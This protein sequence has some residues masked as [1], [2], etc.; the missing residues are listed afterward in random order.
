[1]DKTKLHSGINKLFIAEMIGV[2]AAIVIGA[3]GL[4][5]K[6][7][8]VDFK[9]VSSLDSVMVV[10][11]VL[12]FTFFIVEIAAIVFELVGLAKLRGFNSKLNEAFLLKIVHV[13]VLIL[14]GVLPQISDKISN[15]IF[16][17]TVFVCTVLFTFSLVDGIRDEVPEVVPT[18]KK[19]LFFYTVFALASALITAFTAVFKDNADTIVAILE[20]T[21]L[22]FS[23]LYGIAFVIFLAKANKATK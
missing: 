10:I 6:E 22:V 11:A 18:G 15:D 23:L 17:T 3:L 7:K 21:A 12:L 5:V 1:M 8:N 20:V 9:N 16:E 4:V 19:V 13:F 14:S 2:I